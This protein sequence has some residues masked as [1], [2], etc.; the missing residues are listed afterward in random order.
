MQKNESEA[1]ILMRIRKR[2]NQGP[3]RLFRNNSGIAEYANG[4]KVRYGVG[5]PGAPDL[6]G[7]KTITITPEMINKKIAVLVCVEV[8]RVGKKATA[9]QKNFITAVLAAGGFAGQ[10]E[11][12]SQVEDILSI[13]NLFDK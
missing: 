5:G 3:V 12:E 2:F 8:K 11:S 13:K 10:A 4:A 9:E 6:I 7:F 1:S